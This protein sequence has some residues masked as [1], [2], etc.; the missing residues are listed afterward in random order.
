[1]RQGVGD[2]PPDEGVGQPR[3]EAAGG[4]VGHPGGG[5]HQDTEVGGELSPGAEALDVP[6]VHQGVAR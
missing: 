3:R 4:A 6:H 2:C 1:M 5:G